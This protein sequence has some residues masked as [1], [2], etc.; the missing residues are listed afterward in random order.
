MNQEFIKNIQILFILS[1]FFLIVILTGITLKNLSKK[2]EKYSFYWL[3]G[4]IITGLALTYGLI[5]G[6]ISV[7]SIFV[8]LPALGLYWNKFLN[9]KKKKK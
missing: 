1:P 5:T 3:L 2:M 8:A 9:L 6:N 7:Y 4:F